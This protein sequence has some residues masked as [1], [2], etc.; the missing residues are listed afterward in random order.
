MRF[1]LGYNSLILDMKHKLVFFCLSINNFTFSELNLLTLVK[2]D[3]H[4]I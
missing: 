1:L 2:Q 3:L 4:C